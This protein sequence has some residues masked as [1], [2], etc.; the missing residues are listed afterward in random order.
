MPFCGRLLVIS[1]SF[2]KELTSQGSAEVA[3]HK[4][5]IR[6]MLA[7]VPLCRKDDDDD[8]EEELFSPSC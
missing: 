6:A 2:S 1:F 4:F 7:L 8:D 5:T 3:Q